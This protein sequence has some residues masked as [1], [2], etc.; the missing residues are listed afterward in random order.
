MGVHAVTAIGGR[1]REYQTVLIISRASTVH[2][3]NCPRCEGERRHYF[4]TKKP[5]CFLFPK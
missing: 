1:F 3:L 2:C 4:S 5:Y